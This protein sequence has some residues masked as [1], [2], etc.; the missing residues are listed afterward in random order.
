T[1]NNPLTYILTTAK[2]NAAGHRWLAALS[3]Y[4]FNVQYKPEKS[5]VDADSLSRNVFPKTEQEGWEEIPPSGIKALCKTTSIQKCV[6]QLGVSPEVIP[7]LD[8]GSLKQLSSQDLKDAQEEDPA[9]SQVRHAVVKGQLSSLAGGRDPEKHR[10]MVLQSLHDETGH[11]GVEKTTALIKDHFYWPKMSSEIDQYVKNCGKCILRKTQ[12]QRAAPLK[13]IISNGPMDLVCIVVTDHYTRYAQAFL[14]KDEKALTVAKV[15]CEKYF[16]HYRLPARMHS[17]QRQ[18][19]ESKLIQE[20]LK[21]LGIQ[22]SQTTPYHPQGDAQP[23]Q[24][25]RTLLSMLGTL[26]KSQK[27]KWSQHVSQ[28]VHAYNCT[29][30]DATGY[31]PYAFMFGREARLPIDLCFSISSEGE[32]ENMCLS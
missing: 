27:Q 7:K 16:V 2:L 18:D 12:P 3:T 20:L 6:E 1:D 22:K 11:L 13:Q 23:E 29:R 19:F 25:N 9:I 31:S 14:M 10:P 32:A 28:L 21:M 15:L 17:D 30:N 5:N 26:D 4:N 24:F 8:A